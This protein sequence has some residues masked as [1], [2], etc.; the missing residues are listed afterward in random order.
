[1]KASVRKSRDHRPA[2]ESLEA[3]L[4][5]AVPPQ[6]EFIHLGLFGSLGSQPARPNTPVAPYGATATPTFIDPSVMIK[7][8]SEIAIGSSDYVAPWAML[9]ATNGLMEIGSKTTIQDNA[10]LIANPTG[11]KS[12]TGI[13][14][15]DNVYIGAGATIIG[16][17]IIGAPG[18]ADTSIGPDATI[19]HATIFPGA[20][21]G[22]LAFVGPGVVI[23]AGFKVQPGATILSQTDVE[24]PKLVVKLTGTD[25]ILANQIADNAMLANGYTQVY[26]GAIA[27]GASALSTAATVFNGDLSTVEGSSKDPGPGTSSS[28]LVTFETASVGAKYTLKSGKVLELDNPFFP[29]REIGAVT[30]HAIPSI[31]QKFLG[32]HTSIRADEDQP[33]TV[34][35]LTKLGR[36]VTIHA[37]RGGK[38]TLQAGLLTGDNDVLTADANGNLS[39][40]TN[41]T[42]GNNVVL[43][44]ATIGNGVT[45]GD[46]SSIA[47]STI[48]AGATIAPGTIE[49]KNQVLA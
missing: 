20:E 43:N 40:G 25:T 6:I 15:G 30:F 19:D 18:G 17:T 24:N 5:L 28:P 3:R 37:S 1:M 22:A 42:V 38:I 14:L 9:D 27:T 41:V 47:D 49:I 7:N 29:E 26:Q 39:I 31:V 23:P 12:V 44:G 2:S 33:I 36:D 34:G 13:I 16:P 35:N 48:P 8:A 21:V 11:V 10:H 32:N 45:I 4:V 46:S